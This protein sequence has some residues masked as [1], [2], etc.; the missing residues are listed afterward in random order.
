MKTMTA[1][2]ADVAAAG[3]G[4]KA[5][6]MTITTDSGTTRGTATN[7]ETWVDVIAATGE[8]AGTVGSIT[9]APVRHG[10]TADAVLCGRELR[11][12]VAGI[13]PATDTESSRYALGGTL[14]EVAE[15][16]VLFVVGTDG[17][18]M[19]IGRVQP[20]SVHGQAAPIVPAAQWEALDA[21]VRAAVRRIAG[22]SG[23]KLAA[24]IDR[25]TVRIMVGTHKP[26]GGEV[27][28]ITWAGDGVEVQAHSVAVQGR[29]PRWRDVQPKAGATLT[30][31]VDAVAEAL[32]A[33]RPVYRAA[34]KAA[35]AAWKADR[36][37]KKRQRRYH[38]GDFLFPVGVDC[39]PESIT[40]CGAEWSR[41]VPVTP[42]AVR[43]DH[44]YLADAFAAAAAWGVASVTVGGSDSISAVTV[45]TG[46]YGGQF[47]AVIM[48]LAND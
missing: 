1:N 21:A 42:V 4:R 23:A 24:A 40:G 43:L 30:A 38:G 37:E 15:G 36:E 17:R 19:H 39:S 13:V 29:F 44:A 3:L 33:Y 25:G 45:S 32:D 6:T 28:T 10:V 35:R 2:L 16:A 18:R 5:S 12:I 14:V 47:D 46:E 31:S 20:I 22:V 27:V 41:P 11:R 48:P 9:P 34:E 26:T 7:G 8:P